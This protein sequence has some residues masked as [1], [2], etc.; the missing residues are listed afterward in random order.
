MLALAQKTHVTPAG[1]QYGAAAQSGHGAAQQVGRSKERLHYRDL[2]AL[3]DVP[4]QQSY[5][6]AAPTIG[7][8]ERKQMDRTGKPVQEADVIR[9]AECGYGC[10]IT[11]GRE[12]LHRFEQRPFRSSVEIAQLIEQIQDVARSVRSHGRSLRYFD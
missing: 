11:I 9:T 2:L 5:L 4:E 6:N 1:Y 12:Q 3:N 7:T 8:L 10:A